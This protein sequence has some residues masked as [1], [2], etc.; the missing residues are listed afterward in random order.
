MMEI[1]NKERDSAMDIL[2]GELHKE[3]ERTGAVRASVL[4]S[5]DERI[6]VKKQIV[7]KVL[8]LQK[9]A[10]VEDISM[11]ESMQLA[12]EGFLLYRITKK[13]MEAETETSKA[14]ITI[15]LDE[16]EWNIFQGLMGESEG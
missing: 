9:T 15:H 6:L 12:H 8:L 13:L 4:L 3:W 11:Y 2:L 14:E 5:R 16:E 10:E 7:E 1:L